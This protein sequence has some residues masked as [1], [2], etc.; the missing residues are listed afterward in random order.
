MLNAIH[1]LSP[2]PALAH[3]S[4]QQPSEE[5]SRVPTGQPEKQRL[6]KMKL[7]REKSEPHF[8]QIPEQEFLTFPFAYCVLK[9]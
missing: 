2:F 9:L 3:F 5:G 8:G 4:S 1:M 6:G 7:A